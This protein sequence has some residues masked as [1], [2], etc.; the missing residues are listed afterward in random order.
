PVSAKSAEALKAAATALSTFV[1]NAAPS[2]ALRDIAYTAAVRRTHHPFRAAF[3]AESREELCDR[4]DSFAAGQTA[5][6]CSS[7]AASGAGS[8]RLV[9]VFTG[10]GPQWWAMGRQLYER[11]PVFRRTVQGCDDAFRRA[12]GWSILDALLAEENASRM[13]ETEIAQPANFIVQV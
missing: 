9:F 2:L 4:L 8:P 3:V 12:A 7:G 10:M 5:P 6:C 1:K 11:E 13:A